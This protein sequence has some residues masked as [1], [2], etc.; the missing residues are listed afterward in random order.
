MLTK[1]IIAEINL[2]AELQQLKDSLNKQFEAMSKMAAKNGREEQEDDNKT[3][4]DWIMNNVNNA[5]SMF[6]GLT[7]KEA[8]IYGLATVATLFRG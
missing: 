7:T 3:V 6:E 8:Y 4:D 1:E 2:P 5:A